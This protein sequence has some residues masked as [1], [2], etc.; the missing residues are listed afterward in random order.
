MREISHLETLFWIAR[1]GSFRAAAGQLN[2]SQPTVTLRIKELERS[3]GIRLFKRA[4]RNAVLTEDGIAAMEYAE[5]ILTLLQDLGHHLANRSELTG[6][7]RLGVPDAFALFGLP[8]LLNGLDADYAQL[9]T[10]V[11]VENSRI[12]AQRLSEGALDL[13]VLSEPAQDRGLRLTALGWHDPIWVAAATHAVVQTTAT[14]KLLAQQRIFAN[15]APSNTHDLITSWFNSFGFAP[16][17]ICTCNSIAIIISL[18]KAGV[19]ISALPRCLVAAEITAGSL[20]TIAVSPPFPS[21]MLYVA[22]LKA[23]TNPAIPILT[24]AL[25][26]LAREQKFLDRLAVIGN[27]LPR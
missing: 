21:Q 6:L 11:T 25:C 12:L 23:A 9:K 2:V 15:P 14:A 8:E 7:L 1:L 16:S 3:L 20:V 27:E 13:A 24:R 4:G 18:I 5:R 10:A 17:R 22:S 19:G 26:T